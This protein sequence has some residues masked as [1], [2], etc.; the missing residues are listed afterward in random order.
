MQELK[1]ELMIC[2]GSAGYCYY[3]T[4]ATTAKEAVDDFF[5]AMK[6]AGINEDNLNFSDAT[7][8]NEFYDQIDYITSVDF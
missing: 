8:R 5:K 3:P 1:N 7:L 4:N 2:F 6:V